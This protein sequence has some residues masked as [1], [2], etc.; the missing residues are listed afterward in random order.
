MR[1]GLKAPIK[2]FDYFESQCNFIDNYTIFVN[3]EKIRGK[4]I[5]VGSGARPD[6][7]KIKGIDNVEYL[8]NE[9]VFNLSKCPKSIV[10]VGGGYIGVEFAHFFSAMG[11]EVTILQHGNRLIKNSEPEIS[12][13]LKTEMEKRVTIFTNVENIAVNNENN[14]LKISPECSGATHRT[15]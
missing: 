3:G 14:H 9:N 6:I 11:S 5:F 2:N 4:K 7:P 1:E 8:T 12:D 13:L 10:I 15:H